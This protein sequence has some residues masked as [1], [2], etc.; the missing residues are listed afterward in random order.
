MKA[1]VVDAVHLYYKGKEAVSF[2]SLLVVLSL[3]ETLGL[4]FERPGMT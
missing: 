4:L 3:L 1:H 2:F